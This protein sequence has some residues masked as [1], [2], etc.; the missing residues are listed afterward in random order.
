MAVNGAVKNQIETSIAMA[1]DAI[2]L[3]KPGAAEKVRGI[4]VPPLAELLSGCVSSG[5]KVYV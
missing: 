4:G 5:V 1:G 3:L 2:E